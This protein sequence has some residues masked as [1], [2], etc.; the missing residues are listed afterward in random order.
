MMYMILV[1]YAFANTLPDNSLARGPVGSTKTVV[2]AYALGQAL[3]YYL[4]DLVIFLLNFM[5]IQ[6]L[7]RIRTQLVQSVLQR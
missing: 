5:Q 1:L 7:V 4:R 3:E 6:M 2:Q